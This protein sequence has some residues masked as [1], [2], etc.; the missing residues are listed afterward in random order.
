M[1]TGYSSTA[2]SCLVSAAV[3]HGET[4]ICVLMG[5]TA[6]HIYTDT[7]GIFSEIEDLE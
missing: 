7:I 4:Y 6:E 5:D 2:G 1:K 3:I